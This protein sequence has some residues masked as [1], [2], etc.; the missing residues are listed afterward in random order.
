[1]LSKVGSEGERA[2]LSSWLTSE[3]LPSR[4]E[5]ALPPAELADVLAVATGAAA[6][7]AR[8]AEGGAAGVTR[9]APPVRIPPVIQADI[10]M[11]QERAVEILQYFY[12][13]Y[14]SRMRER[15]GRLYH[16]LRTES[17]VDLEDAKKNLP[18]SMP[19]EVRAAAAR[20]INAVLDMVYAAVSRYEEDNVGK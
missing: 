4:A 9:G 12:S 15:A 3:Y 20:R 2:A 7:M 8:G 6:P 18:M 19:N 10:T 11:K 5:R 13:A 14:H 1:M 17:Q 16:K